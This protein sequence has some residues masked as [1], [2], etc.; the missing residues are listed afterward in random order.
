MPGE[1]QATPE[2]VEKL[3]ELDEHELTKEGVRPLTAQNQADPSQ[4]ASQ[5]GAA[6]E[7]AV[8]PAETPP[9]PAAQAQTA[10]AGA[11]LAPAAPQVVEPTPPP[12]VEVT[13]GAAPAAQAQPATA[14]AP[15]ETAQTAGAPEATLEEEAAS[16]GRLKTFLDEQ[17]EEARRAVQSQHDR[18]SAQIERQLQEAKTQSQAL[19]DQIREL[20][21]RDLTDA[22]KA[23]VRETWAQQDERAQLDSYRGELVDYH[24]TVFVD[25]LVAEYKQYGVT[26][27]SLGA[28]ETPEEMELFCEQQKSASLEKKLQEG[29]APAQP[30]AAPVQPPPPVPAPQP[31]ATVQ[32]QPPAQPQPNAPGV[33]A[34]ASAPSDVGGSGTVDEGKKF[35]E[36]A[37]SDAMKQNLKNMQWDAVRVKQA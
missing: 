14:P 10:Q 18:Q 36:E 19:T 2:M 15:V 22:E 25:S 33:P 21:S 11:P 4:Q 1:A 24:R 30:A 8:P 12:V 26:P 9:Q 29:Q 6:A 3:G 16:L 17:A 35:S 37:G 31:A 32:E 20:E 23:K 7:P 27:E 28:V 34:G 13:P 5:P